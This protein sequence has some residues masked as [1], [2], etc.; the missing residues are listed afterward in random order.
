MGRKPN[1][2]RGL[3]YALMSLGRDLKN[4]KELERREKERLDYL[5]QVDPVQTMYSLPGDPPVLQ[6]PREPLRLSAVN[7]LSLIEDRALR[8]SLSSM[9]PR[10]GPSAPTPLSYEEKERLKD[11]LDQEKPLT[12]YEQAAIL[13]DAYGKTTMRT[14]YNRKTGE[15]TDID[16]RTPG[17][18]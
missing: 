11:K 1:W 17:R 9:A 16:T 13:E 12:P 6:G 8:Q 15:L 3:G 5:D 7:R 18:N 10:Q 14:D 4:Q 2:G